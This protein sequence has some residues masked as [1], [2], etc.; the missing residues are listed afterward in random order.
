MI[1]LFSAFCCKNS[2]T[3]RPSPACVHDSAK[4]SLLDAI[5]AM[6]SLYLVRCVKAETRDASVTDDDKLSAY[7]T[8]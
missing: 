8:I 4:Q 5:F 6:R 7:V 3:M 2:P 1:S